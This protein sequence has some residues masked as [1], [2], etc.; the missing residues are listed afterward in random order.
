MELEVSQNE[1]IYLVTLKGWPA[2]IV[3]GWNSEDQMVT[4]Y[5][6]FRSKKEADLFAKMAKSKNS[7]VKTKVSKLSSKIVREINYSSG[8]KILSV[9]ITGPG[10]I[11]NN[12][13]PKS[14]RVCLRRFV[15]K[16]KIHQINDLS[17]EDAE[18]ISHSLGFT[19]T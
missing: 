19:L 3:A 7:Q 13:Q 4:K 14:Y 15:G 5:E 8:N 11:F 16:D 2:F 6:L 17:K 1:S 18:K 12:F 9:T 10:T